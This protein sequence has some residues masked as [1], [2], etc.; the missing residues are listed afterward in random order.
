MGQ[1]TGGG[2]DTEDATLL[3]EDA[4]GSIFGL[5]QPA[6]GSAHAELLFHHRALPGPT[7]QFA[8]P[9]VAAENTKIAAQ[10]QW[11]SGRIMAHL[12]VDVCAHRPG[13]AWEGPQHGAQQQ[14]EQQG[15]PGQRDT[16]PPYSPM[17]LENVQEDSILC[18][19]FHALP[20]PR[21]AILPLLDVRGRS[22]LELGS[23]TGLPSLV[24]TRL[25]ARVVCK[26]LTLYRTP[27]MGLQCL[28]L[29]SLEWP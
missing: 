8:V 7:L 3:F 15:Q 16:D 6:E 20:P 11:A 2:D 24:A 10:Y 25:G 4:L 14:Q 22:V 17:D 1:S 23:G 29:P 12:L 21:E 19:E 26:A 5:S 28:R 18:D 9:D 13:I 27:G